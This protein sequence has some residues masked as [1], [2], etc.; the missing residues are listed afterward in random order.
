[1]YISEGNYKQDHGQLCVVCPVV[2][3]TNTAQHA[4]NAFMVKEGIRSEKLL[5]FIFRWSLSSY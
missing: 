2:R 1:M 5:L 4:T 3:P